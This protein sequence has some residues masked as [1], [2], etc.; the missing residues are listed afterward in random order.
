MPKGEKPTVDT[1]LVWEDPPPR[2]GGIAP[3]DWRAVL[4]PLRVWPGQ[5]ARVL[6]FSSNSGATSARRA[7]EKHATSLHGEFIIESKKFDDGSALY[8]VFTGD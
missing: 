2:R 7:F 6:T 8:A 1:T 5:W 3:R 4:D